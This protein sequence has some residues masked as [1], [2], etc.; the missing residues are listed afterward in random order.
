MDTSTS[1]VVFYMTPAEVCQRWRIDARTLE[2]VDLPWVWLTPRVR[3][4]SYSVVQRI[5]VDKGYRRL[6]T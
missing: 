3:R 1:E 4:V 2:K 5:E 6:S